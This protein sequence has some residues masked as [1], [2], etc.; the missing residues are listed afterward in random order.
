MSQSGISL[1]SRITTLIILSSV[2]FIGVFT[3]IQ[4]NNQLGRV[5]RFN[6]YQANL[7][8]SIIKNNLEVILNETK[9]DES[10]KKK[11]LQ[12][13]LDKFRDSKILSD[14]V[15]FDAN[16]SIIYNTNKLSPSNN[17]SFHDLAKIEEL[18]Y[19]SDGKWFA[20][21]VDKK[22]RQLIFYISLN[23]REEPAE[24]YTARATFPLTDIQ[25]A[26][27]EVYKPVILTA[28]IVIIAN[29]ILGYSISKTIIGPIKVL[30]Q[31]T[32]LIAA[33]DLTIRTKITTQDELQELGSTFNFMTQELAKM[34]ERAENANPLTKL[35]GNIVIHEEIE[36]RIR[37]NKKFVVIYCDLDNFKAFN[38][39]YGIAKGDVAIKLTAD[40]F[41]DSA[42][43]NGNS[44]DF[45]GH[46]GGDD[47]I[48]I[49]TPDKADRVANSITSEFD[50]KIRTL[51][52][53][54]DLSQGY[55]IAHARDESIK[56]FPIMTI[57]LA[58][59]S[60]EIREISSYAEVT[61]IAAEL[62]KKAKGIDGSI[63]V[64]DQRKT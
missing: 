41:K 21:E 56:K 45:V 36:K 30:N 58:G 42:L 29:I 55:I 34:K 4:I 37:E 22:N 12:S 63:F 51:Y 33:G 9:E 53:Q 26:F 28:I 64:M 5:N 62:K 57:S 31:V 61:N 27:I 38:D 52:S 40:I 46:E 20:S 18:R 6:T 14:A 15:I 54:D 35:P 24:I 43:K 1:Q 10:A 39:K 19:A 50:K 2:T 59:V 49:T 8:T 13:E 17:A 16:G 48:L 3:F 60:N 47:F 23:T 11:Y 32:K 44:D 25:G 7:S